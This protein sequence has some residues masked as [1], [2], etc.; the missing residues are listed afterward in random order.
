MSGYPRNLQYL[1]KRIQGYS[2][3]TKRLSTLN[4]TTAG[5]GGVITVDL[6]SNALID[7]HTLVMSFSGASTG[8]AMPK[9]IE[10]LIQRV[11]LEV[12]GSVISGCSWYNQLF[13]ILADTSFGTDCFN[14]RRILQNSADVTAGTATPETPYAI[15]NWLTLNSFS[16][17]VLDTKLLGQVRLRITLDGPGCLAGAANGSFTL[18]NISFSVDVLA[19]DDGLYDA[20][21]AAY[22]QGGGVYEL[23]FKNY[24][25]YSGAATSWSQSTKFS[26]S[27]QS[28]NRVWATFLN[29]SAN[30]ALDAA[31]A[32]SNYFTRNASGLQS[33][34]FSLNGTYA[35]DFRATPAECFMLTQ[36]SY[37]Q[38]QDVLGGTNPRMSSLSVFRDSMFAVSMKFCHDDPDF[39]FSGIDTRGNS[40]IG[41]FDSQAVAGAAGTANLTCLVFV[42][43]SSMLRVG[44]GRQ[45]ELVL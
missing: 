17:Q 33:C 2:R 27:S 28:L 35:P 30:S 32:N 4:A 16:P 7:S 38:L 21:H 14:K 45:I 31:I 25:S 26:L 9:N 8:A 43:T 3:A 24:L 29:Q 41:S 23:A 34:Q 36:S 44:A 6:P 15:C 20:A 5:P 10:S 37:N 42:E 18:S 1:A 22:L 11:D 40:S 13:N 39:Q 12:N 19:I